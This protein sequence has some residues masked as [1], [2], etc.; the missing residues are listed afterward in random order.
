MG[1][2]YTIGVFSSLNA[3]ST[4]LLTRKEWVEILNE[5]VDI[6]LFDLQINRDEAE[7]FLRPDIFSENIADFYNVLRSILGQ[8]RNRNIDYYEKE[9]GTELEDYQFADTTLYLQHPKGDH[10]TLDMSIALLFIEG[11]V[12]AEEFDTDPVLINWLFRHSNIESKLA[13]CVISA[14]V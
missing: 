8:E 1:S 4:G 11:K 7:A 12:L 2:Y 10:I 13:G 3:T 9:Y 6:Q 14:I 5:R